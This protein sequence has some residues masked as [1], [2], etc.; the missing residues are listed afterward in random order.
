ML[1]L[2]N[3]QKYLVI[4]FVICGVC[5]PSICLADE[6]VPAYEI[7]VGDVLRINTWKEPDLSLEAAMVRS[8]GKIT[9]PLLDD[10]QAQGISTMMLKTEIEKKLAEYVESP[11]VTVTLENPVSQKFYILG[12]V[13]RTG[14]YPIIKKLTVMQAFA[15]SGGFTEWA[16]K[17]KIILI[18]RSEGKD[19]TII[20]KYNDILKGDFSKDISL[21]ADDTIIVP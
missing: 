13:I 3:L 10:I 18:R 12:E 21:M 5:L 14:E 2:E 4:C 11:N 8:D 6:G 19:T 15:L 7:G 1:F 9:F 20:I 17:N 16:S